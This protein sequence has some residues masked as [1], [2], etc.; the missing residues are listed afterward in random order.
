MV[1]P[2]AFQPESLTKANNSPIHHR[3]PS[4]DPEATTRAE[5]EPGSSN[6]PHLPH[7]LHH[8]QHPDPEQVIDERV[9]HETS[10]SQMQGQDTSGS[11]GKQRVSSLTGFF[12]RDKS[13]STNTFDR[14]K[15]ARA[16]DNGADSPVTG[17]GGGAPYLFG[18]FKALASAH[19]S[20]KESSDEESDSEENA[21]EHRRD[22]DDRNRQEQNARTGENSNGTNSLNSTGEWVPA[23]R[24]TAGPSQTGGT[25]QAEE[26]VIV[27]S[28][29]RT[30]S[31]A[32]DDLSHRLAVLSVNNFSGLHGHDDHIRVG[33]DEVEEQARAVGERDSRQAFLDR[34]PRNQDEAEHQEKVAS[35]LRQEAKH[36]LQDKKRQ[37]VER[38]ATEIKE[39][40]KHDDE[41][42]LRRKLVPADIATRHDD[43]IIPAGMSAGETNDVRRASRA[44]EAS[45]HTMRPEDERVRRDLQARERYSAGT[46]GTDDEDTQVGDEE[47]ERR[48]REKVS[49]QEKLDAITEEFGDIA[50]LME[51]DQQER[52]IA[53]SRGALFRGIIIVV[54]GL[55]F[56]ECQAKLIYNS[57][58]TS[59]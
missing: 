22:Q 47:E 20:D 37:V 10:H 39:S 52:F 45:D 36:E 40:L 23:I 35:D 56:S 2:S 19:D 3:E 5:A 54:G 27:P 26:K 58:G 42:T 24:T 25:A 9:E 43:D 51:G 15:Q 29:Y 14:S 49:A 33:E 31:V 13:D 53:E 11:S 21:Q 44:S 38:R 12:K 8:H 28:F 55:F 50:G 7:H 41:E 6:H 30:P 34:D 4:G 1:I 16:N 57:R 17:S 32:Q 48:E 18:L 59:T 46:H